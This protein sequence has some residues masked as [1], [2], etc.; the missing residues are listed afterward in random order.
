MKKLIYTFL[1]I[2][3]FLFIATG[4]TRDDDEFYDSAYVVIPGLVELETQ[5]SYDVNDILWINTDDFS[6]I[7][8]E[9]GQTVPLDVFLT[10]NAQR[11]KFTFYLEKQSGSDWE[12]VTIGSN[13]ITEKGNVYELNGVTGYPVYNAGNQMYE[14]RSGI[15]LTESGSYRLVFPV[16]HNGTNFDMIS[17]NSAEFTYLTIATTISNLAGNQY[18]FTVN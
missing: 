8:N 15:R 10:T 4:C 17:E 2:V 7:L 6:R 9:Y 11:F 3:A 16:G 18:T 5:G 13:F 14:F 12:L 1:P